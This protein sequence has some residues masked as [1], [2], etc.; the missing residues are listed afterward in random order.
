MRYERPICIVGPTA[1]RK[2][3]LAVSMAIEFGGEVVSADSMQV[4]RGMDIGTAKPEESER[5]G[6]PHHMIDVADVTEEWSVGKY[7]KEASIV[8]DDIFDRGQLPIIAG[9]TGLYVDA[10]VYGWNLGGAMKDEQLRLELNTFADTY[11]AHAL[12]LKLEEVDPE[13]AARI[14]PSNLKRVIRALELF[15]L[16]G[17][18]IGQSE[19]IQ[20]LLNPIY[21]GLNIVPRSSLYDRINRRVDDMIEK[22]LVS[23]AEQ[24]MTK[25]LPESSTALQAI[26]Y[27][28]LFLY[29][30]R[31]ISLE[32]AVEEIKK[33]SRNYAK[34]QLT[35]FKRK[36]YYKW[37]EYSEGEFE[38]IK[39]NAIEYVKQNIK[40]M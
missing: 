8:I 7:K 31:Q 40:T 24:L 35:W 2:S 30:N 26:G 12:H 5:C 25:K 27:K 10:L 23:E 18:T 36:E 13:T 9:G 6:I 14:H 21:I 1:S 15:K 19:G 17:K 34:R 39:Q 32:N 20:K 4:Y 22:G 16:T 3:A 38:Q 11:G 28:E 37:F 29:F 33:H